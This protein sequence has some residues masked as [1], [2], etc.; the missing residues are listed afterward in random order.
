MSGGEFLIGCFKG[1]AGRQDWWSMDP[2]TDIKGALYQMTKYI[3]GNRY[4]AIN[5]A[6]RFTDNEA[7]DP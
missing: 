3:S 5:T 7:P 2:V 1:I 4:N 6:M